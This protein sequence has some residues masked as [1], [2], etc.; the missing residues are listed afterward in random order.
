MTSLP[1]PLSRSRA[2]LTIER[3]TAFLVAAVIFAAGASLTLLLVNFI[4]R[5][6][7]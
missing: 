1:L 5:T 7:P 4:L 3:R 2:P 6:T